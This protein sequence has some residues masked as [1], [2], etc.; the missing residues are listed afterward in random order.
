M[1]NKD[2]WVVKLDWFRI[3][4]LLDLDSIND[5]PEF[6]KEK[7]IKRLTKLYGTKTL[8]DLNNKELDILVANELRDFLRKELDYRAKKKARMERE[9]RNKMDGLKQGRIIR[10]DP[11]DF[12]GLDL[13]ADPEEVLESLYKKFMNKGDNKEPDENDED[14]DEYSEDRTGYYI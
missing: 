11:R 14:K 8:L 5:I 7:A 12:E 10:I 3:I 6:K 2:I 9:M 13:N 4:S 1:T